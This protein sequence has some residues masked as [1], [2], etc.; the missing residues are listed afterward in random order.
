[1]DKLKQ[2]LQSN[3]ILATPQDGKPYILHTDFCGV[4]VAAI[5]EQM[6]ADNRA[7]VIQYASKSCPAS[8]M[9]LGSTDGELLAVVWAVQ[10]FNH[11]LAGR[12]FTLVCDNAAL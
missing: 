12:A 1:M 8:S 4:C 7:H 10:K 2:L 9:K 6:Q 11:F 3:P 5:L